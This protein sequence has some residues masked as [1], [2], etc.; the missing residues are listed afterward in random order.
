MSPFNRSVQ[1]GHR[2]WMGRLLRLAARV[3]DSGEIPVA[4]VV[5]D[6][7]GR[8]IGWGTNRRERNQDP[9]GHA[10][11]V[12]LAQAARLLGS[13]RMN[14][15]T[16]LATLEPCPMCAAAI[17]QAR[18][19]TTVFAAADPKRGALGGCLDLAGH[20]SAHHRMVVVGGVEA[21]AAGRQLAEWFRRRRQRRA[22]GQRA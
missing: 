3:G 8:C 20:P 18:V 12:A 19:G 13:W 22:A 17:V 4:A 6:G 11:L 2:Q 1:E 14:Q 5:L 16:L 7:E 10:E 21:E 9:L 15:C